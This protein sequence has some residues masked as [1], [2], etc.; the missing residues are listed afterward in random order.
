MRR[1]T[2]WLWDAMNVRPKT[3][4]RLSILFGALAIGVAVI[5]IFLVVSHRRIQRQVAALRHQAIIAYN[6]GD[7]SSAVKLFNEYLA[8][9]H[10]QNSDAEAVFDYA[11]SRANTPMEGSRQYYEAIGLLENYLTLEPSDPRDASHLLLKLYTQVHYSKEA[12]SRA[13]KLL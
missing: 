13:Q 10:N 12:R 5:A 3:V 8:R 2:S 1:P 9:S 4:R 6:N 11:K 7:Y